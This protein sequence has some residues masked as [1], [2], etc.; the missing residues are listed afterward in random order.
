MDF[1][2]LPEASV[3]LNDPDFDFFGATA[4]YKVEIQA[5][6]EDGMFKSEAKNLTVEITWVNQAP[7][8]SDVQYESTVP[9]NQV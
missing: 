9:E 3:C 5:F 6:N 8:F 4:I 2:S 7:Y 1:V